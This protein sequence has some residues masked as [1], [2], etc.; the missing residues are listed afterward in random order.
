MDYLTDVRERKVAATLSTFRTVPLELGDF[1]VKHGDQILY[2]FERKSLSDLEASIKDGRY[3]EQKIRCQSVC[4]RFIYIIEG[5][6]DSML[7]H[8]DYK[9]VT[10]VIINTILRDGIGI[11]FTEDPNGTALLLQEIKNR[12]DKDPSKYLEEAKCESH[13]DILIKQAVVKSKKNE[14]VT[15]RTILI[16]QLCAI[17]KISVKTATMIID[18]FKVEKLKSLIAILEANP[19][20]LLECT[21]IGKK[22]SEN[23]TNALI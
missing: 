6:T 20:A 22:L 11:F 13:E 23:I 21:G 3:K 14:N 18:H 17:P 15:T 2:I 12:I 7:N 8:A 19:L 16:Q 10:G 4:K 1:Q 5:F 9:S